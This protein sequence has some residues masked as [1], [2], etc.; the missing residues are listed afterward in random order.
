MWNNLICVTTRVGPSGGL[1]SSFACSVWRLFNCF[2]LLGCLHLL[3]LSNKS[4]AAKFEE[5][6]SSRADLRLA[7]FSAHCYCL[8]SMKVYWSRARTLSL[9]QTLSICKTPWSCWLPRGCAADSLCDRWPS[10]SETPPA[11]FKSS[12]VVW[13]QSSLSEGSQNFSAGGAWRFFQLLGAPTNFWLE[14]EEQLLRA[15]HCFPCFISQF[16]KTFHA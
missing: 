12:S 6:W 5:L 3:N 1:Q 2:I 11:A 13:N 10:A 9:C 8:S 15:A 4:L 7:R 14:E 16:L